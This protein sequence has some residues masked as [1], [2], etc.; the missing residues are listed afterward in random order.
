M[1]K[2]QKIYRVKTK[3]EFNNEIHIPTYDWRREFPEDYKWISPD[4]DKLFELRFTEKG[5]N[6][7]LEHKRF[8]KNDMLSIDFI[9]N[10]VGIN[11]DLLIDPK[12]VKFHIEYLNKFMY[13]PAFFKKE[14]HEI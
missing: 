7:L 13:H 5:Y 6:I 14:T 10:C 4:M 9:S 2:K 8:N 1:N 3:K 12:Y 11:K